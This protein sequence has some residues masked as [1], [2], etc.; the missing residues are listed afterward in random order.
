MGVAAATLFAV[1]G[2]VLWRWWRG[3][4]SSYKFAFHEPNPPMDQNEIRH[5]LK[6]MIGLEVEQVKMF[7]YQAAKL[8][9]KKANDYLVALLDAAARIEH[10]H[11]RRLRT[12]YR[13]LYRRPAPARLG[14]VAGW[15]TI[16]MSTVLPPTW[17]AKWD[18]W[19]EQLAIAHYERV[20]RQTT[21]PTVRRIF[22]EHAADER[23]H[24]E[25]FRK[26]EIHTE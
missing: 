19:T 18:A 15:I 5:N 10:V 6:F 2:F 7:H 12:L 20:A 11:V 21:N 25:L 17:M 1:G 3:Y 14:H 4:L 24:R 8:R 23:S 13:Q 26:W 9:R 16:L 22:L